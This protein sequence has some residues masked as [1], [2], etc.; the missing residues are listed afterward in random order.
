MEAAFGL[1]PVNSNFKLI[2]GELGAFLNSVIF[3][4]SSAPQQ[5]A[6]CRFTLFSMRRVGRCEK[7]SFACFTRA[8]WLSF[9]SMHFG[10]L[11]FGG[12]VDRA[13]C[14]VHHS[15]MLPVQF[16]SVPDIFLWLLAAG[17]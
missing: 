6:P 3:V 12:G 1:L 4:A 17:G 11:P 5:R 7:T 15:G 10:A 14:S 8:L 16:C 13:T 2:I 9:L